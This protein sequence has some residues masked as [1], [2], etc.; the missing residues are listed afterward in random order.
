MATINKIMITMP[1][2][3]IEEIDRI[4]S[5]RS[6]FIRKSVK[7]RLKKERDRLMA[8]GYTKERNLEEWEITA[9]DGLE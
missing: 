6:E 1:D 7:A 4:A 8:E 5:N 9:G 3:I 2:Y